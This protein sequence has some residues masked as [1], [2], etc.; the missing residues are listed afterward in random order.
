L[1][2]EAFAVPVEAVAFLGIGDGLV[3]DELLEDIEVHGSAVFALGEEFGE[4]FLE[5]G[6]VVRDEVG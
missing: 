4:E 1:A 5:L 6:D 3:A 2:G